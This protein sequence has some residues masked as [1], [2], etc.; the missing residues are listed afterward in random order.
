MARDNKTVEEFLDLYRQLESCI[1]ERYGLKGKD[2]GVGWL[3]HNPQ[4][5]LGQVTAELD[6]CREVRNLLTHRPKLAGEYAVEPSA[7]ILDTL[8]FT[9]D[10]IRNPMLALSA[11]IPVSKVFS[12]VLAD[13]VKPA[14]VKMDKCCYTHIPIME[15]GRVVGAFSENTLLS[16]L[17][18]DEIM[19]VSQETTFEGIAKY[20][21]LNVHTSESFRFVP[22]AT[23]VAEI[24]VVFAEAISKGDR[25]GMIFITES[26]KPDESLLGIIT[27]W[28]VANHMR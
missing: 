18:D 17:I 24:A 20:L 16:C 2:R 26:G 5:D 12:C 8:K 21:P 7:A 3:V 19:E 14:L 1:N 28:D 15:D 11:G 22:R 23:T 25:V 13:Y 10:R 9:I 6:Y 27:V 4:K